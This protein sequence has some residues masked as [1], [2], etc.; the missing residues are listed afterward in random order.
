MFFVLVRN[1]RTNSYN[2]AIHVVILSC[3]Q[4]NTH[5]QYHV[6]HGVYANAIIY[7]T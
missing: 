2:T 7:V 1:S 3:E 5:L 4:A 6:F